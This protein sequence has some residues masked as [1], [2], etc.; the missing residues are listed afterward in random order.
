MK[1]AAREYSPM[2]RTRSR[3]AR[4]AVEHFARVTHLDDAG[5]SLETKVMDLLCNLRH[6][7]RISGLD[8]GAI[9]EKAASHFRYEVRHDDRN[10]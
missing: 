5:E 6:L 10:E 1:H 4:S 3:W 7:C 2:N 9:D 8:F